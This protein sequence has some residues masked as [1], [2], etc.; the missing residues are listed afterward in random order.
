MKHNVVK[1]P[2]RYRVNLKAPS[3]KCVKKVLC[4]VCKAIA[5]MNL[6]IL[7]RPCVVAAS[8]CTYFAVHNSMYGDQTRPSVGVLGRHRGR[9]LQVAGSAG[10]FSHFVSLSLFSTAVRDSRVLER[11]IAISVV[12]VANADCLLLGDREG[13]PSRA[14]LVDQR[15]VHSRSV[16]LQH[17]EGKHSEL[18]VESAS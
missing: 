3:C 1:C 17:P 8:R 2:M 10:I 4:C 14:C 18:G 16:R 9:F 12:S 5:N 15:P 13:K 11:S 7:S 6:R